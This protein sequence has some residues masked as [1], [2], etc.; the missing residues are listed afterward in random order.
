MLAVRE[1]YISSQF[2]YIATIFDTILKI[3]FAE[4]AQRMRFITMYTYVCKCVF[5]FNV[6]NRL[7]FINDQ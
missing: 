2:V 5:H 3:Y 1:Q 7:I 6:L 4:T